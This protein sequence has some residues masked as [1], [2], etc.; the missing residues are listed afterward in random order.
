MI[1]SRNIN[2]TI[3]LRDKESEKYFKGPTLD[4]WTF[5]KKDAM[6][7]NLASANRI[8]KRLGKDNIKCSIYIVN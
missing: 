4:S 7:L 1:V 8:I 6:I 3:I 2:G 5:S